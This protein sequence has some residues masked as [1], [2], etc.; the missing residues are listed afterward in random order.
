MS[1]SSFTGTPRLSAALRLVLSAALALAGALVPSPAAAQTGSVWGYVTAGGAP[2]AGAVVRVESG[3]VAGRQ[4]TTTGGGAYALAG[5]QP[6]RYVLSAAAEGYAGQRREVTV[7]SDGSARADFSLSALSAAGGVLQ[8]YVT[9]RGAGGP[10]AGATVEIAGGE[11]AVTVS[12]D[13][14]GFFRAPS[15]PGGSYRLR[16]SQTGF[17]ALARSGYRVVDGQV[18]EARLALTANR[19]EAGSVQ[20]TVL[21]AGG[22]VVPR[23]RVQLVEGPSRSRSART[24]GKGRYHFNGLIPGD[25]RVEVFA[26]GYLP[27]S[28]TFTLEPRGRQTVNLTLSNTPA[29]E[30]AVSGLVVDAAGQPVTGARVEILDGPQRGRSDVTGPDGAYAFTALAPGS[31]VLAA[32]ARGFGRVV[33]TVNVVDAETRQDFSLTREGSFLEGGLSGRVTDPTGRGLQGVAVRVLDGPAAGAATVTDAEGDFSLRNLPSGDYNL[34][35]LKGGYGDHL[36]SGVAVA[37][38]ETTYVEVV[39]S[40]VTGG[41]SLTGLVRTT[42]GA[43]LAGVQVEVLRDGVRQASALTDRFGRYRVSALQPGTY[44]ARFS[45]SGFAP[46]TLT[47]LVVSNGRTTTADARLSNSED[48]ETGA[49]AGIVR[50]A[51]GRGVEDALVEVTGPAGRVTTRTA[52]DGTFRL[53]GLAPGSG[54]EVVV[55]AAGMTSQAWR[56]VTVAAGQTAERSFLLRAQPGT[57][58]LT[59]QVRRSNGLPLSGASVVIVGGAFVGEV[60]STSTEGRFHFAALP[61]GSY[62]VE[63]SAPGFRPVRLN[64]I[65]RAGGST[66]VVFTLP[67]R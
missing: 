1:V 59:G 50:D 11:T 9:V 30:A 34:L 2:V 3:P 48:E 27:S 32:T 62:T 64:V 29:A 12:T 44:S 15:L 38:G 66:A 13:A 16:V 23:A 25:Y 8:G 10:V 63:A 43:P 58:A 18:T 51:A 22:Q 65:V 17:V 4:V 26:S 67:T 33:E 47:G 41:G 55:S 21:N 56:G 19:K 28:A 42:D 40:E 57:G 24:N 36:E 60:R 35:F 49:I 61:A 7:A 5:L 14:A 52:V 53:A 45:K 54:Y 20:G 46:A 6:G 39:L 37:L 31:Y